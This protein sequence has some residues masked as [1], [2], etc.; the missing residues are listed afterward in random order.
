MYVT[1]EDVLMQYACT[2]AGISGPASHAEP[3][4]E[5]NGPETADL[6]RSLHGHH[7]LLDHDKR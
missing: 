6:H 2:D 4:A 3:C 7:G 5:L 1:P